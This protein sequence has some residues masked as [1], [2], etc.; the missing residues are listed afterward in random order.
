MSYIYNGFKKKSIFTKGFLCE[1]FLVFTHFLYIRG[2][3]LLINAM[4]S[5]LGRTA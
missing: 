2:C 5:G 1:L 4:F 3:V